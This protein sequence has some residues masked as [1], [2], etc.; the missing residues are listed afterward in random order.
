MFLNSTSFLY[1][2]SHSIPTSLHHHLA[3]YKYTNIIIVEGYDDENVKI[4]ILLLICLFIIFIC[5]QMFS[6]P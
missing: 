4:R 1:Y 3:T 5:V 6:M 2:H